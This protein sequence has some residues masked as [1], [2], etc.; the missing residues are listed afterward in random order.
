MVCRLSRGLTLIATL[1]RRFPLATY[2]A[3]A[4]GFTWALLPFAQ[5]SVVISLLALFGPAAAAFAVGALIGHQE[6]HDLR[7]RV[8]LWRVPVRWYVLALLLPLP[9]SALASGLEYLWGA[10]GAIQFQPISALGLIVFVLVVGEEIGWRGFAL[11]TL[12]SRFGPWSASAILGMLWA[13]WHL[14]L[15]YLE[16]MPQFANPFWPYVGYTVALS[17]ILT[18]LAGHTQGSVVIATVFHG[19]V[20]TFGFVNT[21][22]SSTSRGWANMVS[23]GLAALL[24][25]TVAWKHRS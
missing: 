9:I 4:F 3:F 21:A 5:A 22:A 19:A 23:Y 13:L 10:H 14:P 6:L 25:G 7:S 18:F 11:P 16:G 8:S 24:I 12:L 2:F 20:N 17:I 15:F 1:A